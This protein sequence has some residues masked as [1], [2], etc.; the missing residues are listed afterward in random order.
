LDEKL[1]ASNFEMD[2]I[3]D[4]PAIIFFQVSETPIPTGVIRPKPV[5]TTLL[6]L[7]LRIQPNYDWI[8]VVMLD[9]Y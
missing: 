7:I 8:L 3:P 4:L 9:F 6:L 1:D 5:T 2:E